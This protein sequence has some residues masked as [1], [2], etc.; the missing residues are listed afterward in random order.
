MGDA[1][2]LN[3]SSVPKFQE[4]RDPNA[5][6]L[7]GEGVRTIGA[8]WGRLEH[9]TWSAV[10]FQSRNQHFSNLFS[11]R[12]RWGGRGAGIR[13]APIVRGMCG[14]NRGP[15]RTSQVSTM[16]SCEF[17]SSETA[18]S[19]PTFCYDQVGRG[20]RGSEWAPILLRM[21][22][23]NWGPLRTSQVSTMV[24]CEFFFRNG[25]FWPNFLL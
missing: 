1:K 2:S 21:C 25:I 5:P 11:V 13:M 23:S 15:L 16:V 17:F 6:R 24:S 4:S 19:D 14:S 7:F 18:F 10:D 9:L 8:H 20:G 3:G 22:G 12:I